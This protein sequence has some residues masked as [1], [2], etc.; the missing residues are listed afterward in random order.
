MRKGF[1]LLIL[2]VLISNAVLA[3]VSK[4]LILIGVYSGK[5]LYVQN[6]LL[7]DKH[8]STEEVFVNEKLVLS[9]P[10]T[11]AF[12]I[13]L[14]HLMVDQPVEIRIVHKEHYS[15]RIINA[16]VIRNHEV[17]TKAGYAPSADVF[18]WTNADGGNIRWLTHGEKG[19]GSFEIQRAHKEDWLSIDKIPAKSVNDNTVYKVLVSHEKGENTYRIKLTDRDGYVTY[20]DPF[21]YI[22]K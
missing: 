16:H 22:L 11:S 20:S 19:G 18:S 3:E 6:P 13:D 8:F 7:P 9:H 1:L 17:N 12:T 10:L 4:V 2:G 14:S 5:N 21:R 15:P